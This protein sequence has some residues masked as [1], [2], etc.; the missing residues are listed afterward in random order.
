MQSA[1]RSLKSAICNL[2]FL[3]SRIEISH[4]DVEDL[5]DEFGVA[6]GNGA[7]GCEVS[8][9]PRHG[10]ESCA[11]A[12]NQPRGLRS[13]DARLERPRR[14]IV[15][16]T[17]DRVGDDRFEDDARRDERP[18]NVARLERASA[19]ILRLLEHP[20]ELRVCD[21]VGGAESGL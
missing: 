12:S 14:D 7:V 18:M 17:C 1:I 6:L 9:R 11:S 19:V 2:N 4:D 13:G 21:E 5:P 10:W 16:C 3:P 20:S 8:I 15:M